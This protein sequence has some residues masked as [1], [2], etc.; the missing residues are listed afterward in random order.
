VR[1]VR[2]ASLSSESEHRDAIFSL[3]ARASTVRVDV[4]SSTICFVYGSAVDMA[5][6]TSA[7]KVAAAATKTDKRLGFSQSVIV[8]GGVGV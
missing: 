6:V 3:L 2:S 5:W 1:I 4:S 8:R 7:R